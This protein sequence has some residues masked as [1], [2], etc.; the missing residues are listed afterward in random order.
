MTASPISTVAEHLRRLARPAEPADGELLTAF[1]RRRDESALAALVERHGPMVWGVCRR[2]LP[3]HD[4][5]DAFQATFL[6]L[7]RK[8]A[9]IRDRTALANWLY[10]VARQ[11]AIRAR[12][13]SAKQRRREQPVSDWPEPMAPDIDRHDDLR[14][15]IDQALSR[16]PEK[17]RVLIVLCDLEGR[18]RADVAREL[19]CP[20]G[21]VGGR[22]ARA[23]QLLARR[24]ARPGLVFPAV[25]AAPV[26]LTSSTIEAAARF[27]A[28][29][30][31]SPATL[32]AE[33]VVKAMWIQ[34]I[35][36]VLVASVAA[37]V[38]AGGVVGFRPAGGTAEEPQDRPI[39]ARP[40][41][42]LAEPPLSL[43]DVT[44]KMLREPGN[45]FDVEV[46]GR[47]NGVVSGTELYFYDSQ[48]D[49]AAVHAGLVKPGEKAIITVT[50]VK[51]PHDGDGS[52]RN[53]V[54]S[55]SWTRARPTDTALLLQRRDPKPV[56]A[57]PDKAER[58]PQGL[59]LDEAVKQKLNQTATIEFEVRSATMAWTTGFGQ[60]EPFIVQMIPEIGL[61]DGGEF[62]ICL[63]SKAVTQLRNLGLIDEHDQRGV[64]FFRG[65]TVRLTGKVEGYE[66]REK[67]GRMIYRVC[68]PDLDH[69]VVV[70]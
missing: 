58:K 19:G 55:Q 56:A 11:T 20:E 54:E 57:E 63:T 22:L 24:L 28:G 53:G 32:L 15:L 4:A 5:E 46:V 17:Y 51:C 60:E 40:A 43:S 21:T 70:R 48:L 49:S 47:L 45:R 8:A 16:L 14:S 37:V 36:T 13:C 25:A 7:V 41:R 30:L 29:G 31:V 12:S 10:G 6:V 69:V 52:T 33:G 50:V 9:A 62:Q 34:K 42:I 67:K 27:V 61:K 38:I 65:K 26:V 1:V 59:T 3:H 35:R 23:R 66:D 18:T 68:V 44:G 64:E 2:L 39:R